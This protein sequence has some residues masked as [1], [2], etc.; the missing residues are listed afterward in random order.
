[1]RHAY[2]QVSPSNSMVP[3]LYQLWHAVNGIIAIDPRSGLFR[4]AAAGPRTGDAPIVA[5]KWRVVTQR[6]RKR[7]K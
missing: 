1:M 6:S 7:L 5:W 2:V 4:H 3:F